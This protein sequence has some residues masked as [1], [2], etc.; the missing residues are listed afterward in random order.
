MQSCV[1]KQMNTISKIFHR[2][3]IVIINRA[4]HGSGK[5][6]ISNAILKTMSAL[7]IGISI[8]STDEYFMC[9]NRYIFDILKL[10]EYHKKNEQSFKQSL[11]YKKTVVVCDN[12]NLLP[13]QAEFYSSSARKFGYKIV[14]INFLPRELYTR[15]K[16]SS[17]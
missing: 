13:W 12:T 2:N 10:Y 16:Y 14:F 3:K 4:V 6:T 1:H 8:H 7:D 15:I 9:G 5:T 11:K 17:A